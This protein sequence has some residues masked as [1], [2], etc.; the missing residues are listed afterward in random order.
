[1]HHGLP[2]CGDDNRLVAAI[3]YM[4]HTKLQR[5]ASGGADKHDR[6]RLSDP[7]CEACRLPPGDRGSSSMTL[8]EHR[9]RPGCRVSSLDALADLEVVK[10]LRRCLKIRNWRLRDPHNL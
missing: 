10:L 7:M 3:G 9:T 1:M 6:L 4:P 5:D 2:Q 8:R